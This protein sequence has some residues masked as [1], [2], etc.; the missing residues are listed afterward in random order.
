MVG[1]Q[2]NAGDDEKGEDVEARRASPAR[3]SEPQTSTVEN[4]KSGDHLTPVIL[5]RPHAPA[6]IEV[7]NLELIQEPPTP[8]RNT[9]PENTDGPNTEKQ[10][11]RAAEIE[12]EQCL[13][14]MGEPSGSAA[15]TTPPPPPPPRTMSLPI[16]PGPTEIPMWAEIR[17][18]HDTGSKRKAYNSRRQQSTTTSPSTSGGDSRAHPHQQEGP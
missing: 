5:R 2:T 12:L 9:A 15:P 14:G 13:A 16:A 18:R 6:P 4:P 17:L 11:S 1:T 3:A 10:Q 8:P 7:A